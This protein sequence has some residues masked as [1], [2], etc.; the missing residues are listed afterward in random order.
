[1]LRKYDMAAGS[2]ATTLTCTKIGIQA[3]QIFTS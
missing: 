1:M 3:T 2:T